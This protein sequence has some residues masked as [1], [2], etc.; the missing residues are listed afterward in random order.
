MNTLLDVRNVSKTFT[1]SGGLF[2]RAKGVVRALDDVSFAVP[3]GSTVGLVGESGCGKTTMGHVI[4]GGLAASGG[5]IMF[6]DPGLGPVDLVTASDQT[7]RKTRLNMQMIFQDPNA[8]LNP[9]MTLLDL[10][11]EPLLINKVLAGRALEDRVAEL[12]EQVGLSTR[13]MRRYPHALSGGQRQRVVIARAL[14][15][16]PRLVVADEPISALDVSI[17][18]QT[19]NLMKDL[20]VERQLTYLFIAHDLG[21]VN[22]FTDTTVVMYLGRVVETGR[23]TQIFNRPLHPYSEA[24]I[25]SVPRIGAAKGARKKAAVGEVP[26]AM[27]PP[28]GCHFHPRC[29]YAAAICRT[30]VPALRPMDEGRLV[31]CHFAADLSLTGMAGPAPPGMA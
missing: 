26:S 3:T 13:Y 23:T 12:L 14:S 8:S 30:E 5:A 18:A 10:I 28:A 17:Q 25:G 31:R 20:Q 19:L 6:D 15:L 4:M 24:L 22:H 2:D 7:R 11:G 29:A 1:I 9:R 16:N 27:N 21:V